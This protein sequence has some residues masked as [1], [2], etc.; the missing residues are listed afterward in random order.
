MKK[1]LLLLISTSCFS[2]F[3]QTSA[4]VKILNKALVK[5]IKVQKENPENVSGEKFEAVK[6]F[7]I[8]NNILSIEVKK[9]SYN[10]ED[11]Y[12]QKQAIDLR[13]TKAIV[14]DINIIL[15]TEPDAVKIT[16]TNNKGEKTVRTSDMFFLYLSCE[17][18]NDY[19]ADELINAFKKAGYKIEK[20]Y[21]YD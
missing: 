1:L 13:K 5:D 16:E 9:K 15:E 3:S 2:A 17:K 10:G 19:L 18:Q 7:S 14:K 11:L 21:W 20:G 4:I 8:A 6:S 12:I